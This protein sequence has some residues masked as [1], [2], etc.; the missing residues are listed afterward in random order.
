M[1]IVS[2]NLS[3]RAYMIYDYLSKGRRA[4]RLISTLLVNWDNMPA[5]ERG[6]TEG[7]VGPML[8]VGDIREMSNGDICYWTD[9]GWKVVEEE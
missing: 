9:L 6:R 8:E 7:F 4:S 5:Y 3:P 1:P 2:I